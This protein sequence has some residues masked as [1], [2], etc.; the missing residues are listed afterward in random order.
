MNFNDIATR[1]YTAGANYSAAIQPYAVKLFVA[2]PSHRHPGYV[3]S[4]HSPKDNS[5]HLTF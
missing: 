1:F 4:V 2:S 5:M 3:D